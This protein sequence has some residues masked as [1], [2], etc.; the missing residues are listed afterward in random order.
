LAVAVTCARC[1][2]PIPVGSPLGDCPG[3]LLRLGLGDDTP[4][5]WTGGTVAASV[6]AAMVRPT[7]PAP[8]HRP[9]AAPGASPA[10]GAGVLP[11][12]PGYELFEEVG[13]GGNGV[14]FR[15]RH[16][17]LDR[18]VAVKFLLSGL[19]SAVERHRFRTEAQALA[20][21]N[22]PNAV[23]VYDIAE[24]GGCPYF[25]MEYLPGGSLAEREPGAVAPAR[26]AAL[27]EPIA[28][29]LHA[30]HALG[31][32]HRDLKPGNVLLTADGTPKLTDF[33]I[34]RV[35]SPGARS[36]TDQLTREL[37]VLGTPEYMAP[38]QA[39]PKF[40]PV[41]PATD[42]YGLGAVLYH[43]LTGRGPTQTGGRWER[44][45]AIIPPRDLN[46]AVPLD[47][48]AVCLKCLES[49][50]A[51]RYP[52]AEAVADDLARCGRGEP[53]VARPLSRPARWGRAVG[54]HVRP[55]A[56]AVF[57]LLIGSALALGAMLPPRP[58]GER[59][60][61]GIARVLEAGRPAELI[62]EGGLPVWHRWEHG[63]VP[64]A[65]SRH[66]DGAACAITTPA[67]SRLVLL[68][69]EAVPPAYRLTVTMRH[70]DHGGRGGR[71]GWFIASRE[72]TVNDV[73]CR[74]RL[75]VAYN[76]FPDRAV[77]PDRGA[78]CRMVVAVS[79]P[80]APDRTGAMM[81]PPARF[82][83]PPWGR[84]TPLRTFTAEVRSSGVTLWVDA[85]GQRI[86]FRAPFDARSLDDSIRALREDFEL[87]PAAAWTTRGDIGVFVD[88]G[89]A[90][91][92]RC[93]LER[94]D[95][96]SR[97]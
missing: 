8:R 46:R 53:P 39:N 85:D 3:C 19:G 89:E 4:D 7:A 25:S 21:L 1:L 70:T 23:Q 15:A 62:P 96:E 29:M 18:T 28:R 79:R 52:T 87:P 17:A 12:I 14:V 60:L 74:T 56:A 55:I 73:R 2:Q 93:T 45:P 6:A 42:V 61:R 77:N 47:L 75:E 68:P 31:V 26:A 54:R 57:V 81:L 58:K 94:L 13:R 40:G 22:H 91:F 65:P 11:E 36:W 76:D 69:A 9:P 66:G 64:F 67:E 92:L 95:D 34:A 48:E 16:F 84:P 51:N 63:A 50:P 10:P 24:A 82:R 33:G 72:E 71:V 44:S 32:V 97:P 83:D 59:E 27:V 5:G 30:A 80:D 88:Y 86:P 37:T 20:R 35:T 43:L 41:G 78:N 90:A 38:E 49:A